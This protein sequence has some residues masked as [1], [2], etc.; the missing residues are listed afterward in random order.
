MEVMETDDFEGIFLFKN[1]KVKA[2]SDS[3]FVEE[4]VTNVTSDQ[5][6]DFVNGKWMKRFL[7]RFISPSLF[8]TPITPVSYDQVCQE[9]LKMPRTVEG[10]LLDLTELNK[11]NSKRVTRGNRRHKIKTR[12]QRRLPK[13]TKKLEK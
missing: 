4:A 5:M 6:I 13:K 12:K 11:K 8:H 1:S 3:I 10:E 7:K 2:N 9:A